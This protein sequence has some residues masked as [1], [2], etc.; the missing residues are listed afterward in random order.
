M[1]LFNAIT[2]VL[3]FIISLT[4]IFANSTIDLNILFSSS[5]SAPSEA[6]SIAWEISSIEICADFCFNRLSIKEVVEVKI[7][8]SGE[9]I[10]SKKYTGKVVHKTQKDFYGSGY[11]DIPVRVPDIKEAENILNWRPI[12]STEEAVRNTLESFIKEFE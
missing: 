11:E 1:F 8:E 7:E 2:S 10:H 4:S 9:K 12:V 6:S 5:W 3:G